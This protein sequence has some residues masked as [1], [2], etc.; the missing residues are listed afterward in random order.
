MDPRYGRKTTMTDGKFKR[1]TIKFPKYPAK[2]ATK[3][4]TANPPKTDETATYYVLSKNRV[5]KNN[6]FSLANTYYAV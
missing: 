3:T 5:L 2:D 6:L 4:A 1:K